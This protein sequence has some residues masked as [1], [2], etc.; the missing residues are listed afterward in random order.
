MASYLTVQS[1]ISIDSNV[2]KNKLRVFSLK[3]LLLGLIISIN[4]CVVCSLACFIIKS[5][6]LLIE[7]FIHS[8]GALLMAV[9]VYV[10]FNC[11][12]YSTCSSTSQVCRYLIVK[13]TDMS[14][15]S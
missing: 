13:S 6:N 12:G 8:L 15:A 3:S 1:L 2:S 4:V 7:C 9:F 14:L 10:S 5:I 11:H